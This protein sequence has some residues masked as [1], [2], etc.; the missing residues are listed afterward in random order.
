MKQKKKTPL[1]KLKATF[2]FGS[3]DGGSGDN[4]AR[5][6]PKWDESGLVSPPVTPR[7]PLVSQQ[8]Q[9]HQQQQRL[10]QTAARAVSPQ[11][12]NNA[13][14]PRIS[15]S[16]LQQRQLQQLYLAQRAS[17]PRLASRDLES[18]RPPPTLTSNNES[19]GK[20]DYDDELGRELRRAVVEDRRGWEERERMR[21][22]RRWQVPHG[23]NIHNQQQEQHTNRLQHSQQQ[24]Q[25]Q[26]QR[27]SSSTYCTPQQTILPPT[28]DLPP[29]TT[30]KTENST[31]STRSESSSERSQNSHI[32]TNI[33][34]PAYEDSYWQKSSDV[35]ATVDLRKVKHRE[36]F[37]NRKM[38]DHFVKSD[39][40][41]HDLP[42]ESEDEKQPQLKDSNA[43]NQ[44]KSMN[45]RRQA[46]PPPSNLGSIQEERTT[47]I[48]H[49]ILSSF[50]ENN[51]NGQFHQVEDIFNPDAENDAILTSN[52]PRNNSI[53]NYR[54]RKPSN[55]T[56][57]VVSDVSYHDDPS[58]G[59]MSSLA[60][61]NES[62]SLT[63]LHYRRSH[64]NSS[65]TNSSENSD[66]SHGFGNY[67]ALSDQDEEQQVEMDKKDDQ[68]QRQLQ[69]HQ[70]NDQRRS[71]RLEEKKSHDP[72]GTF[73]DDIKEE[74]SHIWGGRLR[75]NREYHC[76]R[77]PSV[78]GDSARFSHQH[79]Q[80]DP[81]QHQQQPPEQKMAQ[82]TSPYTK[83]KPRSVS[84]YVEMQHHPWRQTKRQGQR[85][86]QQ[87]DRNQYK[88]YQSQD[89]SNHFN[90]PFHVQTPPEGW[91]WSDTTK[92]TPDHHQQHPHNENGADQWDIEF[93]SPT[94]N[95]AANCE[96]SS[97]G[98]L[99]GEYDDP[100]LS[101]QAGDDDTATNT[102]NTV[103]LVAEVKRVW[104]H[105]Q[106]Y[107]KKKK[108]KEHLMQQYRTGEGTVEKDGHD[109][110]ED[111]FDDN[112]AMES[113]MNHFQQFE[114]KKDVSLDDSKVS[115]VTSFSRTNHGRGNARS[116]SGVAPTSGR[117]GLVGDHIRNTTNQNN[118]ETSPGVSFNASHASTEK[119]LA[120][121][122][123]GVDLFY[124]S[125]TKSSTLSNNNN[126][127]AG[128]PRI[129][130]SH[131]HKSHPYPLKDAGIPLSHHRRSSSI[132]NAAIETHRVPDSKKVSIDNLAQPYDMTKS[133]S[134]GTALSS[135]TQ[136]TSNRAPTVSMYVSKHEEVLSGV[137]SHAP[138][139][140]RPEHINSHKMRIEMARKYMKQHGGARFPHTRSPMAP[141]TISVTDSPSNDS[142]EDLTHQGQPG[143]SQRDNTHWT[144]Q[145]ANERKHTSFRVT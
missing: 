66:E 38:Q 123:D 129:P 80:R 11:P 32:E 14:T 92:Q 120:F 137:G 29:R 36:R 136:K 64:E 48:E 81:Q 25:L 18:Q 33:N 139:S 4:G 116:Y 143:Q 83:V 89:V 142:E 9:Q 47:G 88:T 56:I 79:S 115:D 71:R 124:E 145:N 119:D 132:K 114:D 138:S 19:T 72:P 49:D 144:R 82:S 97:L 63:D 21:L 134:T 90:A 30:I 91:H 3:G 10:Q 125:Q 127:T 26:Q 122:N 42:V 1:Q 84:P 95:G 7:A 55:L 100:P 57:D 51:K 74:K 106:R 108:Q 20:D 16:D 93:I 107:E 58:I 131:H 135:K 28:N 73:I 128:H 141:S 126:S 60:D 87:W 105:V 2:A 45:Y 12:V 31:Q 62:S 104:R 13:V 53:Q 102:M 5:A 96:A 112:P 85:P 54:N 75:N 76:G 59:M 40:H 110:G 70:Q 78:G 77:D 37:S 67:N 101:S 22:D 121:V 52:I 23:Q 6:G 50:R 109:G 24:Q 69:P 61:T 65:P 140:P 15:N 99:T 35:M 130:L 111:M 103:D 117:N 98:N 118:V 68:H 113:I 27:Q 8:Q 86:N 17:S 44:P 41:H 133:R 34:N 39:T 43:K 46:T 94:E